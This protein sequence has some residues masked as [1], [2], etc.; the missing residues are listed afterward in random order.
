MCCLNGFSIHSTFTLLQPVGHVDILTARSTVYNRYTNRV[1]P[2]SRHFSRIST[3]SGR[4]P[5]V[6]LDL[7]SK[8]FLFTSSDCVI[9][10]FFAAGNC[11]VCYSFLF[12]HVAF[13]AFSIQTGRKRHLFSNINII[14][15]FTF[16]FNELKKSK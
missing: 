10:L 5:A 11:A 16:T 1:H 14:R 13:C 9:I 3:Y 2:I 15:V 8:V 12:T 7:L 6:F 4:I